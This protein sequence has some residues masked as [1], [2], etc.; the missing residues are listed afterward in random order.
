MIAA[1]QLDAPCESPLR[2]LVPGDADARPRLRVAAGGGAPANF[3]LERLLQLPASLPAIPLVPRPFARRA[4]GIT[5]SRLSTEIGLGFLRC[6]FDVGCA[7]RPV[8]RFWPWELILR[9]L[10]L[11][12]SFSDSEVL[13]AIVDIGPARLWF[14]KAE[15]AD[16]LG[17]S[18]RTVGKLLRFPGRRPRPARRRWTVSAGRLLSFLETR[19]VRPTA[20][21]K[22]SC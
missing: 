20:S 5:D 21:V 12:D 2:L 3:A 11:P 18:G 22:P 7:G 6:V 1:S 17:I 19:W 16:R 15:I 9:S 10:G 8:L 14:S 4:L 13:D